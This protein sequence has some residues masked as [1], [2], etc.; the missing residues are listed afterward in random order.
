MILLMH[1]IC[2]KKSGHLSVNWG[3]EG[4]FFPSIC[5]LIGY[6]SAFKVS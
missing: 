5:A 1:E 2:F 3:I 6:E 4:M